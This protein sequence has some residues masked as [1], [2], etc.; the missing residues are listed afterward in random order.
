MRDVLFFRMSNKLNTYTDTY[1][2]S[3]FVM[4]SPLDFPLRVLKEPLG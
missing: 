3:R 1:F 4:L 2:S